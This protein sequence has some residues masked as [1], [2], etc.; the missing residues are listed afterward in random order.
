[1]VL[2]M[3]VENNIEQYLNKIKPC[4]KDGDLEPRLKKQ[5]QA[6]IHHNNDLHTLNIMF[7]GIEEEEKINEFDA[8][9]MY[10][11]ELHRAEQIDAITAIYN[12]LINN[13]AQQ[14]SR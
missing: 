2:Q 11:E 9:K 8:L 5:L 13:K 10:F 6:E 12:F 7:L 14:V 4:F 1:M 3:S